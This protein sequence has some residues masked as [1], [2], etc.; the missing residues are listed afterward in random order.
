[1]SK[2]FEIF[3]GNMKTDHKKM[4]DYIEKKLPR[5]IG[6]EAVNHF[7]DNFAKEG[8]VDDHIDP[9]KPSKRTD[10]NSPWYGFLY[11]ARTPP[12]N[13]HPKRR[14]AKRK[15]KVRKANAITNYS[16]AARKRKTLSG[17]T[18]DLQES[19]HYNVQKSKVVIKS[20]LPYAHIHNEGG[21]IEVF[22][23]KKVKIPQ[24]KFI[25]ES[26]ALSQKILNR[27]RTDLNKIID[28]D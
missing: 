14:G 24:R 10:A 20:D 15:Y 2:E 12:P 11:G 8:F 21:T 3:L 23:R 26:K 1:M 13:T 25:G 17:T 27:M 19:I 9:W 6:I 7:R 16:P 5:I 4:Q 22:G 18:R 28:N